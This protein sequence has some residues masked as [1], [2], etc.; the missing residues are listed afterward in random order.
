[1]RGRRAIQF[2]ER[3]VRNVESIT[4]TKFQMLCLTLRLVMMSIIG[5]LSL[6]FNVPVAK[7]SSVLDEIGRNKS[8]DVIALLWSDAR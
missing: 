5:T 6:H 8:A 3:G 7:L 2:I 1:M 4:K